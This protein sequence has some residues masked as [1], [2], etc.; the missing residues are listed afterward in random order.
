MPEPQV[1]M[2]ALHVTAESQSRGGRSRG[3]T[4]GARA[5]GETAPRRLGSPRPAGSERECQP[6]LGAEQ[7]PGVAEQ[8]ERKSREEEG[9]EEA[10]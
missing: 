6:S 4:P 5:R 1:G 2:P 7:A 8:R 3:P 10:P 9:R